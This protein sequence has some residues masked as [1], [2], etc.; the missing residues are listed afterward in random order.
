MFTSWK[1][2]ISKLLVHVNVI[3]ESFKALNVVYEPWKAPV[4]AVNEAWMDF[5]WKLIKRFA[6]ICGE[7]KF[8]HCW[9]SLHLTRTLWIPCWEI[10][11]NCHVLLFECCRSFGFNSFPALANVSSEKNLANK[12]NSWKNVG[13]LLTLKSLKKLVEILKLFNLFA[14]FS[15][16]TRKLLELNVRSFWKIK[17]FTVETR[18]TEGKRR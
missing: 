13:N 2:E 9:F 18:M 6:N 14:F 4:K 1:F 16:K 10:R 15:M 3:C 7:K 17:I 12:E 11:E 5:G 8:K